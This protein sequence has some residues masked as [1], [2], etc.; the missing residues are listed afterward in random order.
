MGDFGQKAKELTPHWIIQ[1]SQVPPLDPLSSVLLGDGH[2]ITVGSQQVPRKPVDANYNTWRYNATGQYNNAFVNGGSNY[3]KID[4]GSGSGRSLMAYVRMH[5]FNNTGAAVTM[6]PAPFFWTLVQCQT[7][8]GAYIQNHDGSGLWNSIIES[9]DFDSWRLIAQAINSSNDYSTGFSIPNGATTVLLVPMIGNYQSVCK[10]PNFCVDGDQ[11]WNFIFATAGATVL[12]GTAP[13]LA[14]FALDVQMEQ[15]T[16][17]QIGEIRRTR[18]SQDVTYVYPYEKIQRI[19]QN[20]AA[21]SRF[22]IPATGLKGPVNFVRH[23]FRQGL[24]GTALYRYIPMTDFQWQNSGGN[25]ISG[26]QPIDDVYNRKIQQNDWFLGDA[27]T[28]RSKYA[29]VWSADTTA[30]LS[31]MLNGIQYGM[32]PFTTNE[33]FIVDTAP[34][35]TSEAYT[36]TVANT[37]TAGFVSLMWLT[38]V[39]GEGAQVSAQT[40]PFNA[41][42]TQ[43]ANT[44]DLIQSFEGVVICTGG[45]LGTAPVTITLVGSY[46]NTS[47]FAQGFQMTMGQNTCI[48][49]AGALVVASLQLAV[50]GVN[51]MTNNDSLFLDLQAYTP[52]YLK[53]KANGQMDPAIGG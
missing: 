40:I 41:T 8:D 18:K 6:V 45:P 14:F 3:I 35:G 43:V 26:S 39:P 20:W 51:G 38:P 34:Q 50:A 12:G 19:Q 11:S 13:Q 9:Y 30:A 52:A 28:Y 23:F 5:V 25:P 46:A 37:A 33:Q 4:R 31:L 7:P 42:A 2:S 36:L 1:P 15:L 16:D 24:G 10:F 48:N 29:F 17:S 47:L 49:A 21:S 53:L 27:T 44:I 32:Y 22:T